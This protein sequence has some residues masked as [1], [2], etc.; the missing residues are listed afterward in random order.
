[1]QAVPRCRPSRCKQTHD[2]T[3]A[4]HQEIHGRGARPMPALLLTH[5]ACTHALQREG[6]LVL[7]RSHGGGEIRIERG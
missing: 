5:R 6:L 2:A 1:M 7:M 3:T 4:R